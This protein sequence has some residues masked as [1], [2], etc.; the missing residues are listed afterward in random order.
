MKVPPPLPPIKIVI[1]HGVV[2]RE[3][4]VILF[5]LRFDMVAFW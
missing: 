3:Y 2:L 1:V 5:G 4:W